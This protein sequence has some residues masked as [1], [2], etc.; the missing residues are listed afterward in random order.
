MNRDEFFFSWHMI[1]RGNTEETLQCLDSLQGLYDECIIAVDSREDSDEVFEALKIYPKTYPYRQVFA[2]FGRY[3]LARQDALDR[4][5]EK[6]T[7]IGWCDHDEVLVSPKPREAREW[8]LQNQPD[9]VDIGLHYLGDIGGHVSGHTY[10]RTRIWKK[11]VERRWG[12]PCHEHPIPVNG[13]DNPVIYQGMVLN[14]IKRDNSAYRADHHIELM[15]K[16]IESGNI[17]WIF[18]QAREYRFKG[19]IDMAI[20]R[21]RDYLETGHTAD[22]ERALFEAIPLFDTP[23]GTHWPKVKSF[24]E[25]LPFE[26]PVSLEYLAVALYWEGDH[27]QAKSLHAKAKELDPGNQFAWIRNNDQY[28]Q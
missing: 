22:R 18:Y 14:H 17:G 4:C 27:E 1:I 9:A 10:Y 2:D 12:R 26:H 16:E 7:Y 19:E 11:S 15:Q 13:L 6:A 28:M 20:K 5:S 8:L 25:S 21:Y 3:D 24:M 23:N